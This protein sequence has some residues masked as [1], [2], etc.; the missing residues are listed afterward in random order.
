VLAPILRG[1]ALIR[2]GN[3]AEGIALL[4]AGIAISEA[5]GAKATPNNYRFMAGPWARWYSSTRDG[6]RLP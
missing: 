5:G 6:T 4:K 2:E 1:Q 3:P